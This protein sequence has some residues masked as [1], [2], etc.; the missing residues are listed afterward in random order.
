MNARQTGGIARESTRILSS[1]S[2]VIQIFQKAENFLFSSLISG[3]KHFLV[4]NSSENFA[5]SIQNRIE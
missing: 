4:T 5:A 3:E 1:S 2:S